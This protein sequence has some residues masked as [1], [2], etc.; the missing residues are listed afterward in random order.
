MGAADMTEAL[1]RGL[2]PQDTGFSLQPRYGPCDAAGLQSRMRSAVA[3][4]G[5]QEIREVLAEQGRLE[6][7][8]EFC[9]DTYYFGEDDVFGGQ[10]GGGSDAVDV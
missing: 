4:L 1:L 9:R 7:C 6:V 8:C 5:E 2:G 10:S 3:L